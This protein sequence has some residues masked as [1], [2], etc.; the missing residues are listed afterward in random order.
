MNTEIYPPPCTNHLPNLASATQA[1]APSP[2]SDPADGAETLAVRCDR[3]RAAKSR[4]AEYYLEA[5]ETIESLRDVAERR[6]QRLVAIRDTHRGLVA[7]LRSKM[8]RLEERV[9]ELEKENS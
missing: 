8:S 7:A 5:L 3:Q 1:S 4:W 2:A 6:R 9:A